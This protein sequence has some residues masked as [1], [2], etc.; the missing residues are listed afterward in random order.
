MHKT[1]SCNESNLNVSYFER[2]KDALW[3]TRTVG[4]TLIMIMAIIGNTIV[5]TATWKERY[6]HQPSKYF[7]ACLALADLLVGVLS[8]PLSLYQQFS[9]GGMSS[10]LCRFFV[11]IDAAVET[12]S[13]YTLAIISFDRY[14][15]ISKPFTYNLLMTS[16]KS[17]I[18]ICVVW[19]LATVWATLGMFPY[20]GGR[21]VHIDPI[22]QCVNDNMIYYTATAAFSFFFPTLVTLAMYVAV[23]CIAHKRRRILQNGYMGHIN[24]FRSRRATFYEDLK[25]IRMLA[26]VMGTFIVCWGSFFTFMV[27]FYHYPWFH[28]RNELVVVIILMLPWFNSICNPI[29]YT[30]FDRKYRE[31]FKRLYKRMECY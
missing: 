18:V 9:P 10:V 13:I 1:T 25:N 29:I 31:A 3:Y 15:K 14:L 8:C 24:K 7:I 26:V 27:L 28:I 11:W 4:L 21:G 6:L 30:C 23:L 17:L 16:S 20:A 22:K 5:L 12:A 19:L 2:E